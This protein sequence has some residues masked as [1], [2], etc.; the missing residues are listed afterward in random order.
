MMADKEDRKEAVERL[1]KQIPLKSRA[2]GSGLL[3][4]GKSKLPDALEKAA[5]A[6]GEV[7]PDYS[8]ASDL[9]AEAAYGEK[10]LSDGAKE[11]IEKGVKRV[12]EL[13]DQTKRE[14]RGMKK[15]GTV[16][17]ASKRA[18]GIAQRGK[19]RGRMV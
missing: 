11:R 8:G 4:S 13:A 15:G 1:N 12:R 5:I 19:T 9:D 3:G 14:S 7:H 10:F 16:S 17:S 6:S 2:V 18:D